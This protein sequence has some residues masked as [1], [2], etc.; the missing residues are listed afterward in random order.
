M[1]SKKFGS[2]SLLRMKFVM[3]FED[4][5]TF[6]FFKLLSTKWNGIQGY[7]DKLRE[8]RLRLHLGIGFQNNKILVKER[9]N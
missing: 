9:H 8:E 1:C 2:S 7:R 6:M 4:M 3:K 5:I